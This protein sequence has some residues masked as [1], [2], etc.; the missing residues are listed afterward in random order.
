LKKFGLSANEK[1]KGRKD[2][3]QLYSLGKTIYSNQKRLKALYIIETSSDTPGVKIAAVVGKK[4]GN[5]PWR[6]RYKRLIREV[7]RHNKHHLLDICTSKGILLKAAFACNTYN[8]KSYRKLSLEDIYPDMIDL[9]NKI[10]KN[11]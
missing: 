7:F 6:N 5:A 1:I 11:L 9:I 3:E 10:G 2:F 8:Q 4:S